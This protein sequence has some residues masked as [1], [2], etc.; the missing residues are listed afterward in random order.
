MQAAAALGDEL[1]VAVTNDE[2]VGK[3]GRPI[4]NVFQRADVISALKCVDVTHRVNSSL[5]ALQLVKP[6]I[7]VKGAEY[8]GKILPE[9]QAFCRANGIEIVFT[10]A[11]VFSS[12][13]L[14]KRWTSIA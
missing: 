1:H 4:F 10:R 13:D 3:P 12:T 7:F 8:E 9:D 2:Y 5:A 6:D 11:P 14:L